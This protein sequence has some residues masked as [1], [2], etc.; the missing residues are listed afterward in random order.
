MTRGKQ[1]KLVNQSLGQSPRFGPFSGQQFAAVS[2]SFSVIF[3]V[4]RLVI[5]IDIFISLGMAVWVAMTI[6]FLSG[7]NPHKFWS[8]LYP[9]VPYWIRGYAKYSSAIEKKKVGTKKVRVSR[10]QAKKKKLHP[11]EDDLD[12]TTLV[13][14]QTG[15][16]L[17]GAYLLNKKSLG[18]SKATI[19]L[20]FGYSCIGFHPLFNSD[21]QVELFAQAF[22]AGCKD[23]PQGESLT[24]RW[25][26]FCDYSD[27]KQ[28]LM[29][30][31]KNPVSE[32][33]EFLDYA[34][35]A[36][37]QQLT[38]ERKRKEIKLNAYA[39]FTISNEEIESGDFLD[40]LLVRV[41]NIFQRYFTSAGSREITKN[42]LKK[43]LIK[44]TEASIRYQ[45]LL[46]GMGLV[47]QPKTEKELW[48]ELCK[49]LGARPVEIPHTL[50]FDGQNIWE[51]FAS[52]MR[53]GEGQKEIHKPL[54]YLDEAH[55]A[56]VFLNN[57]VPFADR[58]W[59][60]VPTQENSKKY[61]GVL[62]L[63][64]KP[65]VF[66][67]VADQAR[68]LWDIFSKDSIFDVEIVTQVSPANR[69][70]VR[71]SQQMITKRSRHQDLNTQQRKTVD[72][73]AQINVERSVEAQQRL[74]TGDKPENVSLVVLVYRDTP[75]EVDDACRLIN[76]YINQPAELSRETEYAWLVW[77]QTL[78]LR[79]EPTLVWPYNRRLTFFSSEVLGLTNVVQVAGADMQGFELIADEGHS[80]VKIDL[81][82]PKNLMIIGT[83]GSGKSVLAARII[84]E[85][86]AQGMSVLI[87]DLPND[88]GTGTFGDYTPY[89]GGVYFDI[90]KES[91][92][93][94]QQLN[95]SNVPSEER[96]ER[97]RA[98]RNDVIQII[99]QLVLGSNSS[100]FD[101]ILA[102]TIESVIPLGIKAFY[103]HPDIQRRFEEA[104]REGLGSMAWL[105]TPTLVDMERFFS[106]EYIEL[107]YE[108][109]NLDKA[110]NYVRLRLKYWQA[111]S[112]GNAICRPST[113]D[114]NDKLITF[115]L[116]NLQSGKDAE[117]FAMSAYIAASRQALS[118]ANSVFFMDEASV[119]L[120]YEAFGDAVGRRCAIARKAGSRIVI[121]A[122]DVVSIAR[123]KA[124]VQILQNMPCRFIGRIVPG[125]AK[126]YTEILGIP[127]DIIRKNEAFRPNQKEQ[128]TLWLLDYNNQY[129]RCRY[130]PS[131]A[132]LGLTANSREE[133]AARNRFKEKYS[134]K[135]EWVS[136]FSRYYVDCVKGGK[137][138]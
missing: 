104:R 102:Q 10:S 39:T 59:I 75:E 116:T 13:R 113:F 115:A 31:L 44:A 123:C 88:D 50:V 42:R 33:S 68:F 4:L 25:G 40:K 60:C 125:A 67:S 101:G 127:Q 96:E 63:T 61:V 64:R 130:Y 30:R 112:I 17:V 72:V 34:Q 53:V 137:P 9:G 1:L 136:E 105:N 110:L 82:K 15:R 24:F 84:G 106:K 35:Y 83:T 100:S 57:G 70:I 134:N 80:P 79:L 109:E 117:V 78:H 122:Q 128:Y 3:G 138:L 129:I 119:L 107:G 99:L 16:Q 97:S 95:L 71:A 47:P 22:E 7:D 103:D 131:N 38:R 132:V 37:T 8:K 36:K 52:G 27:A 76:G 48:E 49:D 6:A 62:V 118:T 93:L 51:E 120:G 74:Y 2:A 66:A 20:V 32:E 89:F 121:A 43:I 77:L 41:G 81:S 14:L 5:G 111:S 55:V 12:L 29:N 58:R 92:N 135:F 73:A 65:E 126:S 108:D 85:A 69:D 54:Y 91:N 87:I 11:F 46:D 45:Q 19:R 23:I 90:S 18:D 124:G 86:L 114:S 21:E 98:H 28:Y 26:S 56:S 94:V 133:Q